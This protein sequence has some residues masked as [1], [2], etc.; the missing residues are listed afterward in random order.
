[1]LD[2]QGVCELGAL[3]VAGVVMAYGDVVEVVR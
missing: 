1:M 3:G 2:R